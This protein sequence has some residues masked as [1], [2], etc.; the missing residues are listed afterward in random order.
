VDYTQIITNSNLQIAFFV[1]IGRIFIS[2]IKTR[3]IPPQDLWL[4]D[5]LCWQWKNPYDPLAIRT[6]EIV[7]TKR[8]GYYYPQY[9]QCATEVSRQG[10]RIYPRDQ[11]RSEKIRQE[12][13]RR[14]D[15]VYGPQNRTP[16]EI[17]RSG[18][19]KE[20]AERYW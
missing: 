1:Y 2:I 11:T 4:S 16:A 9:L 12:S 3:E 13:H 14:S 18:T 15:W 6:P 7:R 8:C 19:E 20:A 17:L 10:L 5:E